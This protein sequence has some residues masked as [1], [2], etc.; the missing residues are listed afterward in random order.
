MR[1]RI[2]KPVVTGILGAVAGALNG[3]FGTGGGMI[4]VPGLAR[5]VI[6]DGKKA[7]ATTLLIVTAL[8]L[9]TT[10]VYALSGRMDWAGALPYMLGGLI[11][12]YAGGRW[13]KRVPSH[14]LRRA[15]AIIVIAGGVRAVFS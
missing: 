14:W 6:P 15:F 1:L 9:T 11:G 7:L 5:W 12:G 10:A 4:L 8:S 13:F 2:S 3:F